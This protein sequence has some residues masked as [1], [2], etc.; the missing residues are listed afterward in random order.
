MRK[1]NEIRSKQTKVL[2]QEDNGTCSWSGCWKGADAW[3]KGRSMSRALQKQQQFVGL[4]AFVKSLRCGCVVKN[5]GFVTRFLSGNVTV[6]RELPT[7]WMSISSF[8]PGGL[9][10]QRHF[11]IQAW[12]VLLE[13]KTCHLAANVTQVLAAATFSRLLLYTFCHISWLRAEMM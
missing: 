11:W 10:P 6:L 3:R 9:W 12:I 1:D 13:N 8:M 7:F 4:P 2:P 5:L